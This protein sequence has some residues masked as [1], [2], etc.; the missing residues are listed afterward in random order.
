MSKWLIFLLPFYCFG[1]QGDFELLMG[2]ETPA[3]EHCK[4]AEDFRR[5]DFFK[6]LFEKN[7][8]LEPSVKAKIPKVI[9]FIWLG[10]DPYPK[11]SIGR[12]AKWIELH[13]DWK[14]KFWTDIEREAPHPN[15]E[16]VSPPDDLSRDYYLSVDSRE[17]GSLL[18]FEIL[19]REG[20]LYVDPQTTPF[21]A[22]DLLHEQYEFFCGLDELKPTTFSSSVMPSPHLMG[23]RPGHPIFL[24]SFEKMDEWINPETDIVLPSSYFSGKYR[25]ASS[26]AAHFPLEQTSYTAFEKK[27]EKKFQQLIQKENKEIRFLL[28]LVAISFASL[29]ALVLYARKALLLVLVLSSAWVFGSEEFYDQMGRKTEHWNFVAGEEVLTLERFADQYEKKKHLR[30]SYD[31]PYRIPKVIHFIWLGPRPFPAQSVENVRAWMAR[32]PD[33]TVKYWT[34]RERSAPCNDMEVCYI[35]EFSFGSLGACFAASENWG[36]KSDVLRF[37]ILAKEGGVYV[38]HDANCLQKFDG[39]HRGYDFYCGLE[40]PH[41]IVAGRNITAGNGII[42]AR[43]NHPIV[44]SVIE[45][46]DQGWKAL[47]EKYRGQDGYSRTQLVMERTYIRLTEAIKEKLS[48][49]DIVF[50]ASYFF[51]KKGIRPVYSRHFFANAWADTNKENEVFKKRTNK[52]LNLLKRRNNVIRQVARCA[53]C[54]NLIAQAGIFLYLFRKKRA[55]A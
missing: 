45:K 49:R 32:H 23:G 7:I 26:Y 1:A 21:K 5:L 18:S 30:F 27:V 3:Y 39:I 33:W 34:D 42:G 4:T 54:L 29:I 15:M 52:A 8:H 41:P 10:S 47:G 36:E 19:Y 12:V 40:T 43:A 46:I 37:E 55:S 9:H 2:K 28:S 17:K 13:P 14:F 6:N 16:R 53:L 50:P 44:L 38:D 31:G 25:K 20:G 24:G 11:E 22:F 51:A 35:D 48:D